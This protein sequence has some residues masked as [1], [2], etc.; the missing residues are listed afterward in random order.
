MGLEGCVTVYDVWTHQNHVGV[1]QGYAVDLAPHE[2]ALLKVSGKLDWDKGVSYAAVW[3]GNALSSDAAISE[4]ADCSN[5]YAVRLTGQTHSELRFPGIDVDAEGTY[6]LSIA[7]MY[8]P[9]Y[10]S[11]NSGDESKVE[12]LIDDTEPVIYPLPGYRHGTITVERSL[13][14]GRNPVL[15]RVE[16]TKGAIYIESLGIARH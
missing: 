11:D 7:Y 4:C 16:T 9:S 2:S 8:P 14:K 3:P 10:N 1:S 5:G 13:H 6:S 12:M 15:L